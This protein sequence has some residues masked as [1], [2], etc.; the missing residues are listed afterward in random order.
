ME[1]EILN[2]DGAA[3]GSKAKL[4][5][6]VFGAEPN[7]HSVYLAIKAEQANGRQGT[8]ASKNRKMV[9]GGGKKPWRQKG[10]GVARAGSSRS[11]LWVGG[12][13]AFGPQPHTFKMSLP[14]KVKQLARVSVYSDKAKSGQVKVVEDFKLAE[15]KTREMFKILKALGVDG[16]KNLLLIAEYDQ[17]VLRA[18]RNI[19]KL[20]IRVATTESTFDLLNC[21]NIIIQMGGLDKLSGVLS[22]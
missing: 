6:K 4:P 9:S 13:R 1:L 14:K 10:R 20:E 7:E 22:K 8:A 18:G 3:T 5:K 15:A 2:T 12:G 17:D 11:P 19:P 21:E 16:Q